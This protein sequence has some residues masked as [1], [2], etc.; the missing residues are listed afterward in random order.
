MSKLTIINNDAQVLSE[1]ISSLL[2]VYSLPLDWNAQFYGWRHR[3]EHKEK[4]LYWLTKLAGISSSVNAAVILAREGYWFQVAVLA[5]GIA[6]AQFSIAYTLP[7]PDMKAGEWPSS[8]QEQAIVNH[9]QE[10]WDDPNRPYEN[11]KL[12]P[13]IRDLA[14]SVGHHQK[15]SSVLNPHDTSQ[16]TIQWMRLLSDYTHMAYP[17]LMEL[18]EGDRGYV[19]SGKQNRSSFGENELG[20]LLF[21]S[22]TYTESVI[23]MMQKIFSGCERKAELNKNSQKKSLFR[24]K[25]AKLADM[26]HILEERSKGLAVTFPAPDNEVRKILANFKKGIQSV[27]VDNSND[28]C[29]G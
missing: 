17:Q 24:D 27:L 11:D 12:R 22:Y 6:E 10:T 18:F 1:T 14:A 26:L 20:R 13:H 8:K 28:T 16:T 2:A 25:S 19:L 9:F 21:D 4:S 7:K 29:S 15:N 3:D 23:L 5:R